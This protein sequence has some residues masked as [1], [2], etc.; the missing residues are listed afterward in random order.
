MIPKYYRAVG[1]MRRRFGLVFDME[2]NEID[3]EARGLTGEC[4]ERK[5]Q[6]HNWLLYPD[7]SV[8]VEEGGKR[9][10]ICLNCDERGHM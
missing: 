10:I 9:Y 3:E 5:G 7:W 4:P 8:A 6:G 2:G 1:C